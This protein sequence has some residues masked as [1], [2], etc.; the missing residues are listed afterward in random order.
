MIFNKT[1]K[2]D[3]TFGLIWGSFW[4]RF[5]Q[6][7]KVAALSFYFLSFLKRNLKQISIN[8]TIALTSI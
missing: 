3:I 4:E 5:K 8:K 2:T 6:K 7:K 1:T